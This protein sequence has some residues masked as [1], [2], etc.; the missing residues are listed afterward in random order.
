MDPPRF[1]R[2][3]YNIVVNLLHDQVSTLKKVALVDRASANICQAYLFRQLTLRT[4][5][6]QHLDTV[7]ATPCFKL[8]D[9]LTS[10]P[11]LAT[12]IKN[13]T[14]DNR[15]PSEVDTDQY[16]FVALVVED[17]FL[18][19]VLH[20]LSH[21][22]HLRL[23]LD[24]LSWSSLSPSLKSSIQ[25]TFASPNLL[26]ITVVELNDIPLSLFC[27]SSGLHRLCLLHTTFASDISLDVHDRHR[28]ETLDLIADDPRQLLDQSSPFNLTHLRKI[29][30]SLG[31]S[32]RIHVQSLNLLLENNAS[33]LESLGLHICTLIIA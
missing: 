1:P 25:K 7:T 33:T 18:P 30:I 4:R 10:S 31:L 27:A 13:L 26:D 3:L 32:F 23:F 21:I 16:P 12:R 20:A 28:L 9:I 14:V 22:T 15:E 11:H 8:Y 29:S 2:E 24:F 19:I 5:R 6:M 17:G